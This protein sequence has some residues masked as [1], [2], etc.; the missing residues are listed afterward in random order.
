MAE[1]ENLYWQEVGEAEPQYHSK[2]VVDM[3]FRI[4]CS[5]LPVDHAYSLLTSLESFLP[6]FSNAKN[7]GIHA[8]RGAE[9]GNGW[10]RPEGPGGGVIHP[11]RRVRL[12]LRI[13]RHRIS[14]CA[15][16]SGQTLTVADV[17]VRLGSIKVRELGPAST[18]FARRI[19]TREDE[20]EQE[21]LDRIDEELTELNV[22]A[23]KRLPGRMSK[24]NT[25]QGELL[26]RSLMLADIPAAD[27]IRIQ[28]TGLGKART[29]GC[30][31]FVPHKSISA[32]NRFTEE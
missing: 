8:I 25:P 17:D 2:S 15:G 29:L 20:K 30:G 21:F 13:P 6:W 26:A 3:A 22:S 18:L 4:E 31:L 32:V 24:I 19:V 9:S 28:E 7:T 12:I 27:S 1:G 14:Q 16:L 10:Q 5:H 11:S 23:P